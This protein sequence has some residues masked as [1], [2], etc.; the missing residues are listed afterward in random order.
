MNLANQPD[1]EKARLEWHMLLDCYLQLGIKVELLAQAPDL[2]DMV[3]TANAGWGKK[4]VFLLSNF[5]HKERKKET[6][7]YK[8]W[9][10]SHGFRVIKAKGC[11]EGQG[12]LITTNSAYLLGYG[13]R[14][15]PHFI[16]EL[17]Q[18]FSFGKPIISLE[19]IDPAFYHLDTCLFSWKPMNIIMYYPGAFSDEAL[20]KLKQLPLTRIEVTREEALAF[21]CNSV[22]H[23]KTALLGGASERLLE[24]F[25]NMGCLTTTISS[26]EDVATLFTYLK[27][28]RDTS[29]VISLPVP[30]ELMKGGGSYRCCSL[31]L[32]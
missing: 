28:D 24:L 4:G 3:Y 8:Q 22:Y 31:F 15:S 10:M 30:T 18:V 26:T 6:P 29:M 25:R 17:K 12:D 23:E 19:L 14:T 5:K 20:L 1:P 16:T 9:F 7:H 13:T 21:V 2:Y 27:R 11:F 32:D